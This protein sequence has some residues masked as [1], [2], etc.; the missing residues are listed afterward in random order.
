MNGQGENA[1][2]YSRLAPDTSGL[3]TGLSQQDPR[4][5][6]IPV[7]CLPDS[8]LV[9]QHSTCTHGFNYRLENLGGEGR[10]SGRL[11]RISLEISVHVMTAHGVQFLPNLNEQALDYGVTI[12][13][14]NFFVQ[15]L[16]DWI[17]Y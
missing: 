12:F 1:A 16:F 13:S 7:Y 4:K 3:S 5:F 2:R 8:F 11:V 14:F 17:P 9:P 15:S 6:H 10:R